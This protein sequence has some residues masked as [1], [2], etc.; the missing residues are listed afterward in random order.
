MAHRDDDFVPVTGGVAPRKDHVRDDLESM[1][2][3]KV[4]SELDLHIVRLLRLHPNVKVGF[5]NQDLT[6]LDENTKRAF[7]KD[8]NELL[9]IRPLRPHRK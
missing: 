4:G 5:R 7:L 6:C 3:L 1:L 9:G 2:D 8:M